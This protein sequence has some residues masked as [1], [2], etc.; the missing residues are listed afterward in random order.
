MIGGIKN[1][2]SR[3]SAAVATALVAAMSAV[4]V[5]FAADTDSGLPTEYTEVLRLAEEKVN[6][7][8][9]PGAFGNGVPIMSGDII[10][11]LPWLGVGLAAA[12]APYLAAKLLMPRIKRESMIA[13]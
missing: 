8:T 2:L 6:S 11:I 4:R 10:G 9:Q 12:V 1:V 5:A 7:A 3:M 13:Q